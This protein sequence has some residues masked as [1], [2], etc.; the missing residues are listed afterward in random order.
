[1]KVRVTINEGPIRI[2]EV[3]EGASEDDLFLKFRNEAASRAP[4]MVKLAMKTMSD[5][6]IRQ[7]I[8]QS[9]NHKFKANEPIPA[10]AREFIDFGERV[11]FVKRI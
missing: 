4:F 9:Y 6:T 10:T 8:V 2:D 5:A 1:M 7:Q 11:G 3:I